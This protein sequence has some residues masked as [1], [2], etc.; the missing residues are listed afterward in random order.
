MPTRILRD[1]LLTSPSLAKCSPRAQDAFPRFLLLADD[2]GCFDTNARVL[3]GAGWPLRDDVLEADIESWLA[4]YEAN[5]MLLR[6]LDGDRIYGVFT[7]W[8]GPNGQR[9]REEYSE[10]TKKGSRRKTPRPPPNPADF[11]PASFPRGSR[12]FPRLQ[13]QSQS[14]SQVKNCGEQT[15]PSP[16][17]VVAQ[18]ATPT[19]QERREQ[20]PSETE[21]PCARPELELV[22]TG[23]KPRKAS[24][25]EQ[26]AARLEAQRLELLGAGAVPDL[27]PVKRL[28]SMLGPLMQ[29]AP[30]VLV[31]AHRLYVGD[32][33][34]QGCDPPCPLTLFVSQASRWVSRATR[35]EAV[36]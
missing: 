30:E 27:H 36:P 23:R 13:S 19:L 15:P 17:L 7:G 16:F 10:T 28:N 31:D 12:E 20:A 6:W 4:D 25:Q 26:L 11:L 24:R 21:R 1:R 35:V 2:F 5:G 9:R 33:Y 18:D 14:Q 34:A 8:D 3:I 29:I 22:P 32:E